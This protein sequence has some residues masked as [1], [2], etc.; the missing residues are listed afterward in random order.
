MLKD[1]QVPLALI[2]L[3]VKAGLLTMAPKALHD[4]PSHP[5]ALTSPYLPPTHSAAVTQV[6]SLFL[7]HT[8]PAPAPGPLHRLFPL[9]GMLF[10]HIPAQLTLTDF[11][12]LSIQTFLLGC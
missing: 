1:T 9:S 10:P 5:Q 3:A 12:Q 7:K 6:P 8:E 4:L 11:I 2:L